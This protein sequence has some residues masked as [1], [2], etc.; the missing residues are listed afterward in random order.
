MEG[1]EYTLK[2][3]LKSPVTKSHHIPRP[4]QAP[5]VVEITKLRSLQK[6]AISA[7]D[8]DAAEDLDTQITAISTDAFAA[9]VADV[10]NRMYGNVASLITEHFDHL[11]KL[12]IA[13]A[14]KTVDLRKNINS[15]F[16]ILKEKQL[17][18]LIAVEGEFASLR[19]KESQRLIPDYE[20]LLDQSKAAAAVHDWEQARL[21][22]TEAAELAQ[23]EIEKRIAKVD[24]DMKL[25]TE[26]LFQ[27]QQKDLELLV[28]KLLS[29]IA[30]IKGQTLRGIDAETEIKDVKFIA[31]LNK[32]AKE[33]VLI[34]PLGVDPGPYIKELENDLVAMLVEAKI[35][36]PKKMK[37]N[38]KAGARAP[39]KSPRKLKSQ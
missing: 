1:A 24:S 11:G 39:S 22:Q 36:V 16:E 18:E 29:G 25:Q 21:F 38:P 17:Q 33:L 27:T 28:H 32:A 5:G 8:L 2:A 4:K 12:R 31:A 3:P 20:V 14:A 13:E 37:W 34:T 35:P 7:L 15:E 26:T 6:S 30:Q 10:K 9:A 19:L 23:A